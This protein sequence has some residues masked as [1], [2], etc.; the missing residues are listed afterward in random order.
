MGEKVSP[1]EK[2]LQDPDTVGG[3]VQTHMLGVVQERARALRER[4]DRLQSERA[5]KQYEVQ[6]KQEGRKMKSGG[7][8]SSASKR[9][10]GCCIRGKTRA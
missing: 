6:D 7:K 4:E 10:D 2:Y 8:V 1:L 3:K 9:A 5:Q